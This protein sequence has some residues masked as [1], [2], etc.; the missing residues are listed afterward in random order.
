MVKIKARIWVQMKWTKMLMKTILVC[1]FFFLSACSHS[2]P[3][4]E[5]NVR[6]VS[7]NDQDVNMID[8]QS[9]DEDDRIA[10]QSLKRSSTVPFDANMGD[11]GDTPGI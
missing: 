1:F 3:E 10:L 2:L 11:Y 8:E 7:A 9:P 6:D 5:T 4:L